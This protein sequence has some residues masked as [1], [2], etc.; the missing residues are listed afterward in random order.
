MQQISMCRTDTIASSIHLKKILI[1]IIHTYTNTEWNA[2]LHDSRSRFECQ[3]N[4]KVKPIDKNFDFFFLKKLYH[5]KK[6]TQ[7]YCSG[8]IVTL[9]KNYLTFT[10]S[11][12]E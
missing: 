12:I 7:I 6:N 1:A 8:K 5:L 3:I 2:I 9:D 11:C 4:S 10:Q